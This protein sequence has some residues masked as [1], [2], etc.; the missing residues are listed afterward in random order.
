[1]AFEH[2]I[3]NLPLIL[4]EANYQRIHLKGNSEAKLQKLKQLLAQADVSEWLIKSL[5]G[6]PSLPPLPPHTISS[7]IIFTA[8][9]VYL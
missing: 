9:L 6:P 1:M 4:H 3:S 8:L 2:V 5:N 7:I